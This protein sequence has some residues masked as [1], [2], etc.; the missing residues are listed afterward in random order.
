MTSKS[1]SHHK[2]DPLLNSAVS[3]GIDEKLAILIKR[4]NLGTSLVVQGL[5]H[6]SPNAGGLDLT[7]GQETSPTCSN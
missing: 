1:F 4:H 5:R 7:P 6:H 2:K 3:K